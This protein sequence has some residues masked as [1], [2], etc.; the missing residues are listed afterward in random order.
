MTK[1]Q[2]IQRKSGERNMIN[3]IEKES[4]GTEFND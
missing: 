4:Y 3:Q 2:S 1:S